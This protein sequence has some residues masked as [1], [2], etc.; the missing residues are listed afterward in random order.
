VVVVEGGRT[1]QQGTLLDITAHPRS[2]YVAELVGT[3]LVTGVVAAGVLTLP[4]KEFLSWHT[5][6]D[7]RA[8]IAR[9]FA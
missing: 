9:T 3:N 6:S 5:P 7:F 4:G 8:E 2:R 1:S